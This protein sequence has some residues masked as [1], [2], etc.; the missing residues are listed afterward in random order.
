MVEFWDLSWTLRYFCT[1]FSGIN[2]DGVASSVQLCFVVK[3]E[4]CLQLWGWQCHIWCKVFDYRWPTQNSVFWFHSLSQ[5]HSWGTLITLHNNLYSCSWL[6][7]ISI[8]IWISKF[9]VLLCETKS[10]ISHCFGVGECSSRAGFSAAFY[11]STFSHIL[12]FLINF[13]KAHLKIIQRNEKAN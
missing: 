6:V 11:F 7:F 8:F 9:W 10:F 5:K 13:F 3:D 12:I 1:S 4:P 2:G